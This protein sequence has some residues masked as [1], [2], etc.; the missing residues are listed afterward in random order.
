MFYR[1]VCVCVCVVCFTMAPFVSELQ[2]TYTLKTEKATRRLL[3][4]LLTP[5]NT[6]PRAKG[7]PRGAGKTVS[8]RRDKDM[9][10]PCLN[11][12]F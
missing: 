9:K 11:S 1:C 4:R 5:G 6:R 10:S 2:K 12:A 3:T 7:G 8:V